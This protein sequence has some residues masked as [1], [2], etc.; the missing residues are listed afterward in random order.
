MTPERIKELL[1]DVASFI[2]D[3]EDAQRIVAEFAHQTSLTWGELHTLLNTAA[4]AGKSC[5][6]E[7]W[8]KGRRAVTGCGVHVDL[9]GQP[10]GNRPCWCGGKVVIGK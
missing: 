1:S 2:V 5:Q 10:I 9:C 4:Q 8:D 6:W 3:D 7:L